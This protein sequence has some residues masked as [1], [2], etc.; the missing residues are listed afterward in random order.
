MWIPRPWSS[1]YSFKLAGNAGAFATSTHS[2]NE[3]SLNSSDLQIRGS[4]NKNEAVIFFS[5]NINMINTS[6]RE[7]L[8]NPF[9]TTRYQ[10]VF[11]NSMIWI[12]LITISLESNESCYTYNVCLRY[13]YD[14]TFL[15]TAACSS[16]KKT[17]SLLGGWH[18]ALDR[19]KI[20]TKN[21]VRIVFSERN[22]MSHDILEERL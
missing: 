1:L 10:F 12:K 20:V 13:P 14:Q 3:V 16:P 7:R 17:F 2:S 6:E 5:R 18:T 9:K 19:R 8:Y 21:I 15:L 4:M 22:T 11:F